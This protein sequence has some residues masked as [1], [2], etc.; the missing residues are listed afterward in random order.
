[1]LVD[2]TNIQKYSSIKTEQ[3]LL[4]YIYNK[5]GI[6]FLVGQS[7]SWP[8]LEEIIIRITYSLEKQELLEAFLKMNIAIREL[9]KNEANRSYSKS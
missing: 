1:M 9:I 6:K 8:N 2:F 5:C 4:K 3:D 7:F